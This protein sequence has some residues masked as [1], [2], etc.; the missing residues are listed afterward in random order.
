MKQKIKNDFNLFLLTYKNHKTKN[1]STK[2]NNSD[3]ILKTRQTI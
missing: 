2:K 1:K 3:Y